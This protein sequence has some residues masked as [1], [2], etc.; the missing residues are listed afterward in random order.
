VIGSFVL[1]EP[2]D[3][4]QEPNAYI[5]MVGMKITSGRDGL[6]RERKVKCVPE[7]RKEARSSRDNL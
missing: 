5:F 3:S 2:S 1:K 4:S 6:Y 7:W